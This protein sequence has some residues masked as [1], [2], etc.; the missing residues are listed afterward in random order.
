MD[1]FTLKAINAAIGI[2]FV[3]YIFIMALPGVTQ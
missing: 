1:K 3:L 2:G